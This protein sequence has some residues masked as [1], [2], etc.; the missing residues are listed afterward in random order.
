MTKQ[1]IKSLEGVSIETITDCFN[2]AFSDYSVPI[3]STPEQ[4]KERLVGNGYAPEW[5]TGVFEDDK[6]LA[7]VLHGRKDNERG[8]KL[9]NAGTGAVPA[10]RGQSL[11]LKQYEYLLPKAREAACNGI[12]LEVITDNAPAIHSYKKV[13]FHIL[14]TLSS[15]KGTVEGLATT[16]PFKV[17]ETDTIDW[18]VVRQFWDWR[19][20]WQ[21]AEE[22]MTASWKLHKSVQ[23]LQADE[24]LAYAVYNPESGRVAQF[25][26]APRHRNQGIGKALF[27]YVQN[28]CLKP[29]SVVNV[30]SKALHTLT[31]LKRI[32]LEPLLQQYEMQLPL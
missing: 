10:A 23:V 31:F 18:N 16:T 8:F 1:I 12:E 19:P 15:F 11:T 5:S 4:L 2:L 9:Y 14:N 21:H 20:S 30:D 22:A 29:L 27:T 24:L 7:F 17:Q 13:G 26:V 6:L 32:G 28:A 25:A 3:Q